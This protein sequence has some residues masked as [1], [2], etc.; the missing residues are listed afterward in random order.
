MKSDLNTLFRKHEK[1]GMVLSEKE[2]KCIQLEWALNDKE[3]EK[4]ESENKLHRKIQQLESELTASLT[5]IEHLKVEAKREVEKV[6]V[7]FSAV[8]DLK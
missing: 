3:Q 1:L 4:Q 6:N 2:E 8:C 5:T 7:Y